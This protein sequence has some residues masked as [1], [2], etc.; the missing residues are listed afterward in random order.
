MRFHLSQAVVG[1]QQFADACQL[2]LRLQKVTELKILFAC[3][4]TRV[5]PANVCLCVQAA[6]SEHLPH[7]E[8]HQS[9]NCAPP[10]AARLLQLPHNGRSE[11]Y[12]TFT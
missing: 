5:L 12:S 3:H 8:N 4:E 2:Q 6:V 9:A 11:K 1:L 7:S 10:R